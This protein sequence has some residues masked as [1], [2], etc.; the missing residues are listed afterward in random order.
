[1]K[2]AKT[3]EVRLTRAD[4]IAYIAERD[5]QLKQSAHTKA[6]AKKAGNIF[7]GMRWCGPL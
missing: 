1:M 6:A 2:Q 5:R 7:E 4:M 3:P